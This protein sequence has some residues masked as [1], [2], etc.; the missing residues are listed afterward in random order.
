MKNFKD[1]TVGKMLDRFANTGEIGQ[2]ETKIE[3]KSLVML[4][5]VVVSSAVIIMLLKKFVIK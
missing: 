4:G 2:V 5:L 3:T 1:T